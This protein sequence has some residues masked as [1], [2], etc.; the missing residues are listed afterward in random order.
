MPQFVDTNI[1]VYAFE[2]GPKSER[3]LLALANATI[4]VQVL[5]EFTNVCLRKLRYDYQ[6]LDRLIGEIRSTV[7]GIEPIIE[8]THDNARVIAARYKLSFYD[9]TLIASA[10]MADCDIFYSENLQHGLLIEN[11]LQVLNPFA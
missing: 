6:T 8:E 9:S 4:S 5:N 2:D 10:L 7:A 11:Q 1:V 3:A